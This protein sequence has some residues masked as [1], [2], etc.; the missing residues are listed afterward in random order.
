MSILTATP[1][2]KFQITVNFPNQR[3]AHVSAACVWG[4]A[5]W[6]CLHT[7]VKFRLEYVLLRVVFRTVQQFVK[8]LGDGVC[9]SPT[10]SHCACRTREISHELPG[11]RSKRLWDICLEESC[12]KTIGHRRWRCSRGCLPWQGFAFDVSFFFLGRAQLGNRVLLSA[13]SCMSSC[14]YCK[15]RTGQGVRA[16]LAPTPLGH[17]RALHKLS[18][19]LLFSFFLIMQCLNGYFH[20]VPRIPEALGFVSLFLSIQYFFF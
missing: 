12:K 1:F 6:D 4:N 7:S 2:F 9:C 19:L 5:L 17:W 18:P 3:P 13:S 15:A 16:E 14:T 20:L 11:F 10:L 8:M